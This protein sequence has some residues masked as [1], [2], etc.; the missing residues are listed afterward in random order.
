MFKTLDQNQ[1]ATTVSLDFL[2][3]LDTI[4]LQLIF[5]KLRYYGIDDAYL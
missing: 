4:N 3:A 2:E 1:V 5:D